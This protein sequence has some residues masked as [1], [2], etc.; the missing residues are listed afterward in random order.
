MNLYDDIIKACL[1]MTENEQGRQ[2]R[3][4]N[5][6]TDSKKL[7]KC[8]DEHNMILRKDMAFELGG[9]GKSAISTIAFTSREELVNRDEIILY[10]RDLQEIGGDCNFARITFINFN[11]SGIQDENEVYA[12]M[13]RIDYTRY[14]I[15][16][17]GYMMRI[18]TASERE[19]ARISRRALNKGISFEKVGNV[20][21]REY[22]KHR[23]VNYV[24]IIFIT[25]EDFAYDRL[26]RMTGKIERITESLNLI[27]NNL[28]MDCSSCGLKNVCDE[29]EGL[30]EL[31]FGLNKQK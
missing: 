9:K 10:G 24:K 25:L 6:L 31:H 22:H 11:D 2:L 4:Y 21:L 20:F 18:S 14:H 5:S 19:A 15:N 26:S 16:P 3:V 17:Q 27:F 12:A 1:E 8:D 23:E 30:R 28:V 13:K 29:V 7:W